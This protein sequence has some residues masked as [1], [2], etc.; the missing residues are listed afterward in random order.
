MDPAMA[1]PLRC[2]RCSRTH[3]TLL[4]VPQAS[5]QDSVVGRFDLCS[6]LII[7]GNL[8]E[9]ACFGRLNLIKARITAQAEK[10]KWIICVCIGTRFTQGCHCVGRVPL[11][12][13]S[14]PVQKRGA[15]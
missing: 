8:G 12:S 13:V 15:P 5:H 6:G 7:T 14:G 11:K 4:P 10:G 3:L 9:T 2:R 1:S